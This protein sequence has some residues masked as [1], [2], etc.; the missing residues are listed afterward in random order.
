[1]SISWDQWYISIAYLV[2]M[3][4]KDLRTWVGA[5][6]VAP[7]YTP[8]SFGYNGFARGADDSQQE[9]YVKPGK[10]LYGEHAER[11]AIYNAGRRGHP[12]EGCIM[13]LNCPPC[14]PCA[15]AIIQVG[16]KRLVLHSQFPERPQEKGCKNAAIEYLKE[17]GV[18]VDF[19]DGLVLQIQA[20]ND[21]KVFDVFN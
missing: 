11:N 8:V 7:D 16:I 13:Y 9:R 21:G 5:V 1:M 14:M 4:S 2:A 10:D 12:L 6:I 19:Y 17:C 20:M 18:Q 3:K 15:R